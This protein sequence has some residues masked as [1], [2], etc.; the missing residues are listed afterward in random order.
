MDSLDTS[1][2]AGILGVLGLETG[3]V[4]YLGFVHPMIQVRVFLEFS[5][6]SGF[7][8]PGTS[9]EPIRPSCAPCDMK[10]DGF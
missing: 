2:M 6:I 7:H 8:R 9:I 3:V 5:G 10:S 4:V 1:V